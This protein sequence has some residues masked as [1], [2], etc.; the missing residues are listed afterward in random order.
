MTRNMDLVGATAR[1]HTA[2]IPTNGG[3]AIS[4]VRR[5]LAD[6]FRAA[7]IDSPELDARILVAH[8]LRLDHA[9]FAAGADRAID[10]GE[11]DTI[12]T[13]ARRRLAREPVSRILGSKEFW[14]H[15]FRIDASTFVPRPETETVVEAALAAIDADGGRERPLRI[16]D[17]GTGCGTLLLALLSELPRAAGLGTDTSIGALAVARGNARSLGLTRATFL[18]CDMMAALGGLFDL[19]VSN[20]PYIVSGDIP[21]LAPE[22]RDFDPRS[23]LDGGADGLRCYRQI[24]AAAPV[25]LRPGGTVIVELGIGQ[26]P[27]VAALFAAAGL[28]P[29][30]P[31][32]D[33]DG[34]PRALLARQP[35]A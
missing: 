34:V 4:G 20:P 14:S 30:A 19:I 32:T 22:V 26:A 7:G 33:L 8:A 28:A 6:R 17:I 23:A 31:R 9:A 16:A 29:S 24:A 25:R 1:P 35:R 5:A 10:R 3:P 13:L 2:D 15:S 12:A 27:S 18:A 11:A 21:S